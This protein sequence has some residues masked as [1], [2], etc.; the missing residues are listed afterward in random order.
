MKPWLMGQ[1]VR[2]TL[3]HHDELVLMGGGGGAPSGSTAGTALNH[4]AV[5]RVH[6]KSPFFI[7]CKFGVL[8]Y[9][10]LKFLCAVLVL[11]LEY[12]DLYK[13]GDFSPRGGYL[14]ICIITNT[15]QCWAL[16]CLIFFYY[17]TKTELAAIRPVGKFLSVKALVFFTWWQSVFIS[18]LYQLDMIPHYHSEGWTPED[19]AKAIQD[20]LICIEMFLAAV[21]HTIVF[22]HTE[23]SQQAVEARRRALNQLPM[24]SRKRLGRHATN[25]GGEAGGASSRH[26]LAYS[27]AVAAR[28]PTWR[29]GG[30]RGGGGGD[31]HSS[32]CSTVDPLR[33]LELATLDSSSARN[34]YLPHSEQA[35]LHHYLPYHRHQQPSLGASSVE[36]HEEL[37][38]HPSESW[39]MAAE[40][41]VMINSKPLLLTPPRSVSI[42]AENAVHHAAVST[43]FEGDE[44]RQLIGRSSSGDFAVLQPSFSDGPQERYRDDDNDDD[45]GEA[46]SVGGEHDGDGD[47]YEFDDDDDDDS[48]N[49]EEEDH[50]DHPARSRPSPPRSQHQQ[51]QLRM[52]LVE[53]ASAA[54]S[55][56]PVSSTPSQKPG[57]VSALIDSAIPLDLRDNTVGIV[58][59]DYRVE[60]KTLLHHAT[61]S[62]NYD[63][64][65]HNRRGNFRRGGGTGG[66]INSGDNASGN[67][68]VDTAESSHGK[69][70]PQGATWHQSSP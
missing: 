29:R 61:T 36:S 39:E 25:A 67:N 22:P 7:N 16:Y 12:Y 2:K 69:N 8:Q 18:V 5:K 65:S 31:D 19:V 60:R 15:S 57:F 23:Y 11:I 51:P 6:W 42:H 21:V 4:R 48:C 70:P 1:P 44:Q 27:A 24:T 59:G 55:A 30:R 63:L 50:D 40:D 47:L 66:T 20:Y 28:G 49:D 68:S 45:G 52:S 41:Q 17:A 14:Y 26:Y 43:I 34:G 33:E 54:A 32:K 46:C 3:L 64:F 9:V 35:Q 56:A 37:L 38:L 53:G 58:K 62:D 13:E 10:L